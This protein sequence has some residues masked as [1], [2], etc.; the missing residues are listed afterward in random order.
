M[1]AIPNASYLCRCPL[2]IG[3]LIAASSALAEPSSL[4]PGQLRTEYSVAPLGIDVTKP[5]FS[6]TMMSSMRA[7]RQLAYQVLVSASPDL[8][9]AGR[10]D[11]WDSG[12]IE[13]DANF[14]VE[15]GGRPLESGHRYFWK[16][17][18]WDGQ[19][20]VSAWSAVSWWEMGLLS[21]ADWQARWI[22]TQHPL[23]SPLL[24]KEFIAKKQ[25]VRATVH[26]IGFGWYK[27]SINGRKVTEHV[28][29]P[30][31]SDY[32]KNIYYDSYDVSPLLVE[33]RNAIGLWLGNG[34]N[35]N[36]SK[37][38]YRW[39]GV[40]CALLQLEI[41]YA[42]GSSDH[43]VTD[44][45]WKTAESPI[46][47]ND[48]YNGESYDARREKSGW[49]TPGYDDKAWLP[50]ITETAPAGLLRACLMPPI[51][52]VETLRPVALAEPKPG[53]YVFDLGQNI[54][55][56]TRLHVTAVAGDRVV[57][58]H[59]EE[60]QPDGMLDITTN[61]SALATDT[62]TCNGLG[63][64]SYEPSF[65]YHGFRYVEVT[66]F[67]GTPTLDSVEGRAIRSAVGD[68]GGFRSSNA[69]LNRLNSNFRWTVSNN[70]MGIPT[71]TATR[72][73]RTPCSMD[74]MVVTETAI[75]NF[76]MDQYYTKWLQDIV[77]DLGRDSVPNWTGD[78]VVLPMLLYE[79]YGDRRVLEKYFENAK[80]V[81]DS[82]T[83]VSR[84]EK[85][86]ADSYG[87]WAAPNKDGDYSSSFSEGELVNT[88]FYYRVA[89]IT[90]EIATLLGESSDAHRYSELADAIK[91]SFNAKFFHEDTNSYGSGRQVTYILPLAFDLVP[92]RL[93]P[94]VARALAE[95]VAGP[96]NNH[97]DTGIFGTRY[98]FEVLIDYGYVDLAFKVLTQ[99][100]YPSY[101][102]QIGLGATTTWEQ[103]SF[104]GVMQ[105]HDHAM[106]SG[107]GTTFYTRFG[108]IRAAAPGYREIVI[109]PIRP[110][111][112]DHVECS[113]HTVMGEIVS[114]WRF[115][116]D[117]YIHR[118]TIPA[119]STAT[120]YVPCVDYAA[121]NEGDGPASNAIGVRFLRMEGG[122]A[123]FAVGSGSYRF[124]VSNR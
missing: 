61:R 114:N 49:N 87:D 100:T 73:E 103:W 112:L 9:E 31:N 12:R 27:L 36:Y 16:V 51:Q 76:D 82:F 18:V 5:R 30:V 95:R 81:T 37:Y 10:A 59:A 35:D 124:S 47:A 122:C 55:G 85:P 104:R 6:W 52:V 99:M 68:C 46:T 2:G 53:V 64:E 98:L 22:G 29:T 80:H 20:R 32:A 13:S 14:G 79:F 57:M 83:R 94:A 69:L 118:V 111:A 115:G 78:Q 105:S 113:L 45:T 3:M 28:L 101:G 54:A 43:V 108:G 84:R 7:E 116:P 40:K 8:L 21:E 17:R 91:T 19:G 96:D 50:A 72:D 42:D 62:Y 4:K 44:E 33:G 66:G 11:I 102:Y 92:A 90:S 109:H 117:E 25:I 110:A 77:G 63:A 89:R 107:P 71:D 74:S 106:Y 15:Y 93:R 97:L 1:I 119:N 70:L 60:I 34:Y 88:A 75:H 48:I 38:G 39:L 86:W 56:W 41:Q 121:V 26:V 120:V 58:R 65:T 23:S 67:P 24:R 123:V